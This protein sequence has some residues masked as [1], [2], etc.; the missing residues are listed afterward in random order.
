MKLS[1][2]LILF[3]VHF[4][5][6][7]LSAADESG[8]I[9]SGGESFYDAKNP[10]ILH[11]KDISYCLEMDQ[12]GFP[13]NRA[14]V[15]AII[16]ESFHYWQTEFSKT[17]EISNSP[18]RKSYKLGKNRITFKERC[19]GFE[20]IEFKLGKGQLDQEELSFLEENGHSYL[21]VA[22]RKQYDRK[23]LSGNGFIFIS[24]HKDIKENFSSPDLYP[25]PWK[26]HQL[27]MLTLIHELGHVFGIPHMGNS[28]MAEAFLDVMTSKYFYRAFISYGV[29]SFLA[30]PKETKRCTL[31]DT[32]MYNFFT[33]DFRK[34][35]CLYIKKL[36]D[37]QYDI[38]ASLNQGK[39]EKVASLVSLSPDVYGLESKPIGYLRLTKDQELFR[40]DTTNFRHLIAGP[41]IERYKLT[42]KLINHKTFSSYPVT[43][44]VSPESISVISTLKDRFVTV[45]SYDSLYSNILSETFF[46]Q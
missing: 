27:L 15:L 40:S 9:S 12:V 21:G 43:M 39:Q 13:L 23:S 32:D 35:N 6:F 30:P 24:S 5:S 8:W 11:S 41:L 18:F 16:E 26:H 37:S 25:T 34:Y 33:L 28:I 46:V 10:W 19:S 4:L 31:I 36:S 22:V 38:Y 20:D 44:S 14:E 29:E 1:K 3:S 17:G 42:G 2:L 45:Y 7:S